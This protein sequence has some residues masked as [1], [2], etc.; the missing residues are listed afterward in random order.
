[1]QYTSPLSTT[2]PFFPAVLKT[3]S[4][5][6]SSST[7]PLVYNYLVHH[8]EADPDTA[9]L[10]INTIQKSLT[11]SNP[12]VRA[13][14]LKT[15]SAIRVPVIS[16]IVSLA[17]KRGVVDMSPLV[18]KTSAFACVKCIRLDPTTLPQTTDY[19]AQLLG[20]Q[21]YYVAG[22]AVAAFLEVCPERLDLIHKHYRGLVKKLVDMDEWGQL[23]TL[24]LLT[25]YAR[26]C[27]PLRTKR[28]PEP[29]RSDKPKDFYDNDT[30]DT[31]NT[32][33]DN[34]TAH[35]QQ[36]LDPDLE[37][38]LSATLPLLQSRTSA[39]V[40]QVA[41]TYFAL[42]PSLYLH[43]AIGPLVALLRAPLDIRLIA[44][45]NIVRLALDH[46]QLFVPH[47]QH[48][49]LH[50]SDPPQMFRIKLEV[51]SLMFPHLNKDTQSLTLAEFEHFSTSHDAS[52]VREAVR[53][54]GRCAQ[55][56]AS[57]TSARCLKLLLRQIYAQDQNLVAEALEVIRHL[58]QQDPT[59]HR[60][61]VVR[62]AKNL[63]ALASDR[64][65]ASVIW[66]VGEFAS[67]GRLEDG[68]AP[69]VL[70][71]LIGAYAAQGDEVKGQ[72]ILLAAKVYLLWLNEEKARNLETSKTAE[73]T[74]SQ[75]ESVQADEADL[76]TAASD[77]KQHPIPLLWTHAL[78]LAR[79]T[80]SYDIRDR[81]RLFRALLSDPL[82]TDLASLLLLAPKPVP[83]AP[84]PSQASARFELGS[85]SLVVGE[86]A[87]AS[88]LRGYEAL[89]EWVVEGQEPDPKLRGGNAVVEERKGAVRAAAGTALD[90]AVRSADK[91]GG[92][93]SVKEKTLDSWLAESEDEEDE[94]TSEEDEE[95]ED[96]EEETED[97]DEETEEESSEDDDDERKGLV[98]I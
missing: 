89:P 64:A 15:M 62:L 41:Q 33:E 3:L 75:S 40:L 70:R 29:A 46:A 72:I 71:I 81:A 9:L 92:A 78:V 61:T 63:D 93:G 56:S 53:A 12:R 96:S 55:S 25:V 79:Y 48:F 16:Q 83:Q 60:K 18:R 80:P 14:A 11:D 6:T 54:I 34:A 26:R 10:A 98:G 22:A 65:K 66:L 13:M 36:A 77:G 21:Q 44:L 31:A 8:A 85:A 90:E 50:S 49:I 91:V 68:V 19:L 82:S 4:Q 2:L 28:V 51:L 7:R 43:H 52:I 57:A 76:D 27:F 37:L 73:S 86:G 20:D 95:E 24:K 23:A 45:Y 87:G 42:A 5:P 38:F 17:I 84:S 1:M 97:E 67:F 58:I 47:F 88:G 59:R 74:N 69:D 32:T 30:T 35:L 39:V 94:E